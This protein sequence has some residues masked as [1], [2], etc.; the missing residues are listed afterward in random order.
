MTSP[1]AESLTGTS[2]SSSRSTDF[3]KRILFVFGTRPEAIKLCP[4][5]S[6]FR[7][8]PFNEILQP[9][10]C[11]TGQHREMLDQVLR[12]FDINP[13]FDLDVMRTGQ[14]LPELTARLLT[15]L[16]RVFEQ[17]QPSLTVVQGDTTTTLCGALSSFYAGPE[18]AHV[19]AGLRTFHPRMPFPEE[20]NRVL[21]AR[22]ATLHFAPTRGAADNLLREGVDE[23]AIEVTGNTGIDAVLFVRDRL[24]N[25]S[26]YGLNV[27]FDTSRKLIVITAHRRESFGSDFD[28]I[29]Q[30]VS[31]LAEREDVQVVWPV[32]RNPNVTEPVSRILGGKANVVL[33]EPLEYIQFIDLMQRAYLLITDSGGIQ[34]EGPSLGKPILVLR[35]TTERPEAVQAGTVKLVG[36]DPGRIVHETVHLLDSPE[37]YETM[38][39]LHNPYG[40]GHACQRIAKRIAS[41]LAIPLP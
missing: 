38:A 13:D 8:N 20:M 23:S 12:V 2:K 36:T 35:N 29:C 3:P 25:G 4:L 15:A 18:V 31:L 16:P 30:A 41:H 7:K 6:A 21:T 27:P 5:I 9:I 22:L 11:V 24:Q 32:H 40:D 37:R 28:N 33:L 10:V 39:R 14:S 1:R 17:V 34:E 26:I 19:E